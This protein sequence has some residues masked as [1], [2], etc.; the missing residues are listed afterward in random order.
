[1]RITPCQKEHKYGR[2]LCH[3]GRRVLRVETLHQLAD[4][5]DPDVTSWMEQPEKSREYYTYF[6]IFFMFH[7]GVSQRQTEIGRFYCHLLIHR[8]QA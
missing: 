5:S 7:Q 3:L 1:M 6:R 8:I 4:C 2:F